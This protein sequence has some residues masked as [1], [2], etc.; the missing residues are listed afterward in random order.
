M[1]FIKQTM[2]Q[3]IID[4]DIFPNLNEMVQK[5]KQIEDPPRDDVEGDQGNENIVAD[6]KTSKTN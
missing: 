2:V 3:F 6:N 1:A 5:I 4:E